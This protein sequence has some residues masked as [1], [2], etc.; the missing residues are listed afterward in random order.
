MAFK[1]FCDATACGTFNLG[2]SIDKATAEKLSE[3]AANGRFPNTHHA[4]Q[5][6]GALWNAVHRGSR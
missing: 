3:A 6:D 5:N 4:D 1:N 2:I